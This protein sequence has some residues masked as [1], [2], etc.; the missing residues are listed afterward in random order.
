MRLGGSP[1]CEIA[2]A[3]KDRLAFRNPMSNGALPILRP[4]ICHQFASD[5]VFVLFLMLFVALSFLS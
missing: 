1:A 4:K 3:S 2:D 5:H